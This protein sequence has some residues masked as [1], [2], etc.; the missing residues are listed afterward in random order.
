MNFYY[1][2]DVDNKSWLDP[3]FNFFGGVTTSLDGCEC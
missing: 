2:L 3:V 1:N